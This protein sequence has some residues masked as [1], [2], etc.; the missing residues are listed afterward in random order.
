MR[1]VE[2]LFNLY[3]SLV[4]WVVSGKCRSQ[5]AFQGLQL[6]V[7]SQRLGCKTPHTVRHSGY[8]RTLHEGDNDWGEKHFKQHRADTY[9]DI[10]VKMHCICSFS[11]ANC[12]LFT[13]T[14]HS[15]GAASA[16]ASQTLSFCPLS[17][18]IQFSLCPWLRARY[19]LH[20]L[21]QGSPWAKLEVMVDLALHG[22]KEALYGAV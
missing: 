21:S 9:R 11:L 14:S 19:S 16:Q 22:L 15:A 6:V 8:V 18:H 13:Y 10:Q 4:I 2:D 1:Q 12:R 17:A 20:E 3:S 5:V 7:G